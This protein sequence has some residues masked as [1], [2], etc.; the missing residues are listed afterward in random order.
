MREKTYNA[1]SCARKAGFHLFLFEIFNSY[2]MTHSTSMF[3]KLKE[4]KPAKKKNKQKA[5]YIF[6]VYYFFKRQDGLNIFTR[7]S[8]FVAIIY[9]FLHNFIEKFLELKVA[10]INQIRS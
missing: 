7:I 9:E 4:R 8:R 10:I 6:L 1:A 2:E 3:L 5:T